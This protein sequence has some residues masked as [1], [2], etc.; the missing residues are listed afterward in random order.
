[1]CWSGGRDPK[2]DW[3]GYYR[4]RHRADV[5]AVN[6]AIKLGSIIIFAGDRRNRRGEGG[7]GRDG[8]VD[9]QA[10]GK[11]DRRRDCGC[12]VAIVDV[13]EASRRPQAAAA[14]CRRFRRDVVG[15]VRADEAA[16]RPAS[17]TVDDGGGNE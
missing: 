10:G 11:G 7:L 5:H 12:I 1:M 6:R 17:Y 4:I 3:A 8:A 13:A 16:R 14:R 2:L 15:T 9:V